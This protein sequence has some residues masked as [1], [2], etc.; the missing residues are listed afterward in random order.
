[1][2]K[3]VEACADRPTAIVTV[4]GVGYRFVPAG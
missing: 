4:H 1:L 2:R 3:K